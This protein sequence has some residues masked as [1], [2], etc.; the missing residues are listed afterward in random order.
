MPLQLTHTLP[1]GI[2]M[3]AAYA[4]IDTI[5]LNDELKRAE[6][7]IKVYLNKSICD[8]GWEPVVKFQMVVNNR[9][10]KDDKDEEVEDNQYDEYFWT[11]VLWANGKDPLSQAYS[12]LQTR[13][14]EGVDFSKATVV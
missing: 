5:T 13:T 11:K 4:V 7:S 8:E 12:V 9:T 10:Y 14:Y 2:T 3:D 6:V 1:N